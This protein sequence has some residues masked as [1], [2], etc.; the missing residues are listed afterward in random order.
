MNKN[1]DIHKYKR[2]QTTNIYIL[3]I[4]ECNKTN[5]QQQLTIRNNIYVNR[6]IE[7]DRD[8]VDIMCSKLLYYIF[9][10]FVFF[11]FFNFKY[12]YFL[13]GHPVASINVIDHRDYISNLSCVST[14]ISLSSPQLFIGW[15]PAWGIKG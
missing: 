14:S 12:D 9:E 7:K 2:T 11:L 15:K 4:Y 3:F 8:N 6:Q 5:K 10:L 1:T 13:G